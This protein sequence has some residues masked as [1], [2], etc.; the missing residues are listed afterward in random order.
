MQRSRTDTV[1]VLLIFCVFATSVFLV[2]MLGASTYQN[3]S[4]ISGQGQ[5]ERVLLSYIRTKIRNADSG[6]RI[7]ISS[8]HGIPALSIGEVLDDRYFVTLI[9]LY[10][11]W[12]RELFHEEGLDFMLGES[13][14]VIRVD[15]LEFE[16]AEN[17]LIRVSTDY[18]SMLILPR[19]ESGGF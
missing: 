4:E 12:V 15:S 13:I 7:Y 6:G 14:P 1:F 11:G 8:H 9:Y 5:N 16:N 3:M 17:G 18:G 2:L 10:D 19:T